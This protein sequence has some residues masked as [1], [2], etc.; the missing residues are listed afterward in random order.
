MKKPKVTV[1]TVTLNL[2][3]NGRE[4]IFRQCVESVHRQTYKNIEHLIIDGASTDGTLELIAEYE[5][6]GWLRCV[7]EPDKGMADAM[8]KGIKNA[9]GEYIAILNSDDYY[10]LDA[11]EVSVE[12]LL[13]AGADYT[14]SSSAKIMNDEKGEFLFTRNDRFEMF[15]VF[16]PYNH[17]TMLCKKRVLEE[18]GCLSGSK[19]GLFSDHDLYAKLIMNDFK[20]VF[21]KR[22]LLMN[23]VM[24][25]TNNFETGKFK[26]FL[27]CVFQW[28]ADFWGQFLPKSRTAFYRERWADRVRHIDKEELKYVFCD[29]FISPLWR[30]LYGKKLK[31]YS[32]NKL[33]INLLQ[34]IQKYKSGFHICL[35]SFWR[36]PLLS[37]SFSNEHGWIKFL[38][39]LP[40]IKIKIYP[41]ISMR[42]YVLGYIKIDEAK[43][44]NSWFDFDKR[45]RESTER[46]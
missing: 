32:Y 30:F 11:I 45:I 13:S 27:Q 8:N 31:H 6:K 12:K 41:K 43:G 16:T 5:K 23:R 34:E 35:K 44:L 28:Y 25:E 22:A 19:Y 4:K 26:A 46:A 21:I 42:Y 24:G 38:G 40:I 33:F 3:K 9:T 37:A 7:S 1:I 17:E 20:P 18:V 36:L 15:F 39:F 29:R 14:S 2:I 10:I